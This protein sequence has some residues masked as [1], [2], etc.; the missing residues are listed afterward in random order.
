MKRKIGT[1]AMLGYSRH[2]KIENF[3]G[4][5]TMANFSLEGNTFLYQLAKTLQNL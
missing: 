2:C 3:T 1:L 4:T 5:E